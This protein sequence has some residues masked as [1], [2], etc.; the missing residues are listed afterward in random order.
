MNIDFKPVFL[1]NGSRDLL[2]EWKSAISIESN[3]SKNSKTAL[4]DHSIVL[5]PRQKPLL[6]KI[7]L[8]SSENKPVSRSVSQ[9]LVDGFQQCLQFWHDLHYRAG[10]CIVDDNSVVLTLECLVFTVMKTKNLLEQPL[11]V[12]KH[13]DEHLVTV[14]ALTVHATF[15]SS[16]P[17]EIDAVKHCNFF[18]VSLLISQLE[19]QFPLVFSRVCRLRFLQQEASLGPVSYALTNSAS[20]VP[21]LIKI[22][23]NDKTATTCCRM[24]QIS[25]D[26]RKLVRLLKFKNGTSP[27]QILKRSCTYTS[28]HASC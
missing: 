17:P 5:P 16:S 3:D 1:T 7:V 2:S 10:V 4:N 25:S 21:K 9:A 8:S 11:S 28:D 18:L 19:F 13:M 14:S 23:S 22:I 24:V 15:T 26:R 20:M 12:L 27:V 6:F